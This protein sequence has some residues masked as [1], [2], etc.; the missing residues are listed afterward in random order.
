MKNIQES[1]LLKDVYIICVYSTK[2][3]IDVC[4][5]ID[6]VK[7]PLIVIESTVFPGTHKK[8][9]KILSKKGEFDLVFFPHRY[10]KN[11][12]KH[13]IFNQYR[14]MG[15]S[16]SAALKRAIKFYS[17]F[18]NPALIHT[19]SLAIAEL[20]K[21]LENAY[22]FY[23]IAFA[24]ELKMLCDRKKLDFEL[25]RKAMNTKWNIDIKRA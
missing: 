10:N 11:D 24:E 2:Q 22:R 16:S 17:K 13:H 15:A 20:C 3:V 9:I 5:Q 25:L 21:P 23:E 1:M 12:P 7:K 19:T 6:L 18:M 4:K 8:L 14:V